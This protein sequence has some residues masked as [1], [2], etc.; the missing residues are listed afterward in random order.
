M[1]SDASNTDLMRMAFKKDY[2]MVNIITK[3]DGV[4]ELELKAKNLEVSY[5]KMKVLF[6]TKKKIPIKQE[7]YSLSNKIIKTI[8]YEDAVLID[9]KY[10]PATIIIKDELQKDSSTKLYYTNIK[11][12]SSKPAEY[13]T[14]GSLKK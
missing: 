6:D 2:E 14:L 4:V 1:G 9:G 11:R 8:S 5:N 3:E 10:I 7:M 13:F 12:N